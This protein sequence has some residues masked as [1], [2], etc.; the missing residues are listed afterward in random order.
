MTSGLLAK[1]SALILPLSLHLGGCLGSVGQPG[2]AEAQRFDLVRRFAH[3]IG[4]CV[5][6]CELQRVILFTA[7]VNARTWVCAAYGGRVYM[8]AASP[9]SLKSIGVRARPW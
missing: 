1:P 3:D 4:A 6:T 7:W 5:G 9:D 8:P 2:G